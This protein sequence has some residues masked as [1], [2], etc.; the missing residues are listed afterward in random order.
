MRLTEL[1]FLLV[2]A[3][4][5]AAGAQTLDAIRAA[6]HMQCG[7]V[8]AADD[9]NGQDTHG[10][11]SALGGEV[12]RAVATAIL[13]VD[14]V[15]IHTYPAE[16]ELLAALQ[17]GAVQLAVGISP[18][19]TV[20]M[21][22]GVGFGPPVYFDS[23]RALVAKSA[24]ITGLDGLRDKLIC[25]M[26]LSEPQRMLQEVMA[27]R[28]IA[29]GLQAHSEQ[30]EMDAAIAVRRCT[31]GVAME[32]RLADSRADFPAAAPEFVFL[33]ERIGIAPVVPA[34]RHG[35]QAFGLLVGATVSALL[36]AEALGVSADNVAAAEN[37]RDLRTERLVGHDFAIAQALGL[38]HDWAARV[39]AATGNYGEVFQRTLGK[40]YHLDRG[41]NALWTEGGLMYP[42]PLY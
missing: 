14:A 41:L 26:N 5:A 2:L 22:S 23:V 15:T 10:D 13:G 39:I 40:P 24:G 7:T 4:P 16:P 6:K 42:N 12:C 20:A 25:A 11:L 18:S 8:Q 31:A 35:D 30:G 36:E 17:S 37:R 27:A 34:Y 28:G 29:Y 32:S 9:W 21:R 3:L 33:P 38:A 1:W 19:A